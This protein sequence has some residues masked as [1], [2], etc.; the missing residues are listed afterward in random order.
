[1]RLRMGDACIWCIPLMS[2]C[3]L[4]SIYSATNLM[5]G[6]GQA[7]TKYANEAYTCVQLQGSIG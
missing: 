6:R 4:K 5:E 2:V 3:L 7:A 1:M